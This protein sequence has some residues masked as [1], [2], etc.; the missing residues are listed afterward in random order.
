MLP[1]HVLQQWENFIAT[2]PELESVKMPRRV[3]N[4][5]VKSVIFTGFAYSTFKAYNKDIYI[6]T[7]PSIKETTNQLLCSKSRVFSTKV[8]TTSNV[9]LSACLPLAKL[10]QSFRCFKTTSRLFSIMV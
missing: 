1:P 4:M 8:M 6:P 9:E 2:L 3:L 10:T 7:V 5:N